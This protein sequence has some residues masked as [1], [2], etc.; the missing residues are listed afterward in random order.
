MKKVALIGV[1]GFG[2]THLN[3]LTKLADEGLLDIS[4]AVVR[5]AGKAQKELETLAQYHTVIYSSSDELFARERG[6]IDLVCI[7]TGIDSHESLTCQ[8]MAAGVNVLLEKPAAGSAEAVRRM[9]AAR[10]NGL[11][12]A[13][14]FQ[15]CYAP[16]IHYFKKLLN[17]GKLGKIIRSSAVGAWPR[18][19]SYYNRNSWAGRRI[20]PGGQ[21]VLDSPVNNAFAHYLNLL[22]FLNG[23]NERVT[24]SAVTVSGILW[25]ARPDIEMFDACHSLFTLENGSTAEIQ[26]AHCCDSAI[27]PRIRV[28]CENG[29]IEWLNNESWLIS[30]IGGAPI[31][32]GTAWLPED[33]M[34]RQVLLKL[35]DPEVPVYTLQNALEHTKCIELLDQFC[36]I[37]KAD[38]EIKD[39]IYCIPGLVERFKRNFDGPERSPADGTDR[40]KDG[41]DDRKK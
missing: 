31:A 8:A 26:F 35:D 17:S 19:D 22:L 16:E 39:G 25:R 21:P 41:T 11:F 3:H 23:K 18:G 13:V 33:V 29:L 14:G 9:I 10:R 27:T 24:A 6:R 28:E 40:E 37:Q 34:F 5:N 15:H 2:R 1:T 36:R 12:V 7:P 4:A 20:S 38:S 32:S 30:G